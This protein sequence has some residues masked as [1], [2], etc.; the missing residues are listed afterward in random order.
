MEVDNTG[1][2]LFETKCKWE[3][4]VRMIYGT[5]TCMGQT[6]NRAGFVEL[7]EGKKRD[8]V[9]QIAAVGT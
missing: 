8:C 5:K 9:K 2:H 4:K 1:K 3:N 7:Y 6:D